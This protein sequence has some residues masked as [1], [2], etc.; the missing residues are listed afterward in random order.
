MSNIVTVRDGDIIAAEIN[1][2]KEDTRRIMIQSAIRIG[3]KLVEAKSLV[4]FGE[5]CKWL[6]EKVDYSQSTAN[7]LM[8]LYQE[9]GDNQASLFDNWTN[10]ETFAN[11]TY[12]QHMALLALP[13]ADRAEFAETHNVADMSTRELDKAVREEIERLKAEL[14]EKNAVLEAVT[15]DRDDA[16]DSLRVLRARIEDAEE[17]VSSSI[18]DLTQA[19]QRAREAEAEVADYARTA[20]AALQAQKRAEE[21][22]KN[23]L[24]LVEKLKK[25][26]AV[27]ESAEAKARQ[28]LQ[29]ALEDPAIPDDV[30][31]K[32]RK[33]V[34]AE[35]AK[36]AADKAQKSMDKLR[37]ELETAKQEAAAA[38]Q[39]RA[40]AEAQLTAAQKQ[41]KMAD[42]DIIAYQTLAQQIQESY[43][44]LNGYRL[45]VAANNL[46]AGER[47][48]KFQT[49]ML[50][51]W[52]D[53]L[54]KS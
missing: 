45:K 44:K 42:P 29:K 27:A 9:Y 6:E 5:W 19:K 21:S 18:Q 8:K 24:N 48:K 37:K 51:Q 28:D 30:M 13:F 50:S 36:S 31:A 52:I 3:G 12:T 23:A 46:D 49:A 26:L 25:D 33:E 7:N 10:S 22:E 34:E 17:E 4:P 43:N 39:A 35:A 20:D 1:I 47:L 38:T 32:L 53:V 16:E 54:V 15:A 40:D 11:L 41:A 14:E 2:I